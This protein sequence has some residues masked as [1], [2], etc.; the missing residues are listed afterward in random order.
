MRNLP[1]V[2]AAFGFLKDVSKILSS[3]LYSL[4]QGERV[5]LVDHTGYV[6]KNITGA[7]SNFDIIDSETEAI[8]G[9]STI[10]GQRLRKNEA[11]IITQL[12]V[13]YGSIDNAGNEGAAQYGHTNIAALRNANL[14]ISQNNREV[15]NLP[16][17]D[18]I[19]PNGDDMNSSDQYYKL[20]AFAYL[21]DDE[22]FEMQ[23]IFPNGVAM[24]AVVGSANHY[25]EVMW[26]GFKTIK[27]LI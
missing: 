24:P 10:K 21:V 14:V 11:H 18:L 3:E 16:L 5:R 27:N 25:L 1:L 22:D 2:V 23:V 9:V 15:L 17:A 4:I 7:S 20:S 13:G 12:A 8:K 26:K 6:R 19:R